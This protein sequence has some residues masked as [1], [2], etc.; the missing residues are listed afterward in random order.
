MG[1]ILRVKKPT[2]L[3]FLTLRV[4]PIG[5]H[6]TSVRNYHYSLRN[7]PEERSYRVMVCVE[8]S[9]ILTCHY[10]MLPFV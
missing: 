6:E 3:G 4:G 1:P 8:Y 2:A 5:C 9:V 10:R 7:K